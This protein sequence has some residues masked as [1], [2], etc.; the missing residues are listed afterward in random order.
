MR[1]HDCPSEGLRPL[2]R[3]EPDLEC[4]RDSR[5]HATQYEDLDHRH[6]P[7]PCGLD[8]GELVTQCL[9]NRAGCSDQG[10]RR[11]LRIAPTKSSGLNASTDHGGGKRRA[12]KIDGL[13]L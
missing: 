1:G 5:Q 10:N 3:V 13:G 8:E 9:A 12:G 6:C 7:W 4:D 2:W 11:A